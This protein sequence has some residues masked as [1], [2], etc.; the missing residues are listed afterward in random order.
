MDWKH[1]D[2][3][4]EESYFKLEQI[5]KLL[6]YPTCRKRFILNYFGDEED[7][8]KLGKDCKSCDFCVEKK[9]LTNE[10]VDDFVKT[11]V[12]SIVLE[13]VKKFDEKF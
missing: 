5:K 12:F 10:E 9:K 3:L 2:L 7:L 6:F 4:K 13:V 11:S 1:Q 8:A